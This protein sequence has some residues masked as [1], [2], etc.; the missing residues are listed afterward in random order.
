VH[1][2][3]E[4]NF[5]YD[6]SDDYERWDPNFSDLRLVSKLQS[7]DQRGSAKT[8]TGDCE[9]VFKISLLH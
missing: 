7:A 5:L 2:C 1:D 8:V 4:M 6:E 9:S 3:S